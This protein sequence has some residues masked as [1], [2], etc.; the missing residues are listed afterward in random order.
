MSS[1]D[2]LPCET[3]MLLVEDHLNLLSE[4]NLVHCLDTGNVYHHIITI[5]HP[6]RE[7]KETLFTRHNQTV[8]ALLDNTKKESL[9][10][11]HTSFLQHSNRQHDRQQTIKQSHRP[12]QALEL[13]QK[14]T[15]A[16]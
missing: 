13:L 6:A 16:D 3:K 7:M 10:A 2:H 12:L 14:D 11:I 5:D 1:V 9:Q 4:Q 8:L 15:E